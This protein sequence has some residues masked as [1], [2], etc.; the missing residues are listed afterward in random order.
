MFQQIS[1]VLIMSRTKHSK[2]TKD[3]KLFEH[4]LMSLDAITHRAEKAKRNAKCRK[5]VKTLTVTLS[6]V[7]PASIYHGWVILWEKYWAGKQLQ[8]QLQRLF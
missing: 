8:V 5:E 7:K 3:L 6:S 2:S 4:S 1:L